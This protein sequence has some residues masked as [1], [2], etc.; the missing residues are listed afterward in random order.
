[1]TFAELKAQFTA[2]LNRTD[3]TDALTTIFVNQA[4]TRSQRD[5]RIPASEKQMD[6][7]VTVGFTGV[8]VPSDYIS[9]I[10]LVSDDKYVTY[11]PLASFLELDSTQAGQPLYWT[12]IA[13]QLVLKPVPVADA[14]V[15]LYYYGEFTPFTTEG[16]ST[17]I[18]IVAPDLVIYG[19]LS[20]AAD[21]YLDERAMA[22]EQRYQAI[23]QSLQDQAYDAD[24]PGAVQ[25][26]AAFE[27]N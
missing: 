5:L 20:Y 3:I 27:E 6:T 13:S 7:V 11:L 16:G 15:S 1:M 8:D 24:G 21:Y 14:V 19:A 23:H 4:L 12:R 2:L 18:S 22:F 17:T 25:P 26:T 10:A 9:A